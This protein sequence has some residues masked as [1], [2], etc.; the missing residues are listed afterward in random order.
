M[1][2]SFET[3]EDN[4]F[5]IFSSIEKLYNSV[6]EENEY[7]CGVTWC[8]DTVN[9]TPELYM[10]I[11]DAVK[12]FYS[13]DKV[14]QF[15]LDLIELKQAGINFPEDSNDIPSFLFWIAIKKYDNP[16]NIEERDISQIS[17]ENTIQ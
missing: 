8:R 6:L 11:S 4:R 3:K 16:I 1:W 5:D 17:I 14:M 15:E 13:A 10:Q 12:V 2:I 7:I 9:V